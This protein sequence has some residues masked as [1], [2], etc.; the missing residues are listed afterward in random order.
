MDIFREANLTNHIER[1]TNLTTD[2]TNTFRHIH[3]PERKRDYAMIGNQ[4]AMSRKR[5]RISGL[6]SVQYKIISRDLLQFPNT[7]NVLS[8]GIQLKCDR[9]WTPY[10]D[11]LQDGRLQ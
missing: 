2:R 4:K 3:G 8:I 9:S 7:T 1:P 6:D 10:C 5:D 11:F